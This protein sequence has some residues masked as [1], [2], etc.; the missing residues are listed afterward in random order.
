[1]KYVSLFSIFLCFSLTGI[2]FSKQI[3][4]RIQKLEKIYLLLSEIS[5]RIE[6]T[7]ECIGNILSSLSREKG[8]DILPFVKECSFALAK[9]ESFDLSW[10]KALNDYHNTRALKKEDIA[11][12]LSFGS[13]FGKS[14]VSG[15]ISNC[16]IHKKMTE[17]KLKSAKED[18]LK[19]SKPLRY[20]GVLAGV[21]TVI[22]FF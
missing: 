6:Y 17:S 3:E 9:G 8:Y 7:S 4:M 11:I 22:L 18:F 5:S 20:I 12:L 2:F 14:D 16:E 1:M 15:Q 13:G 21:A 10:Q 19:Y